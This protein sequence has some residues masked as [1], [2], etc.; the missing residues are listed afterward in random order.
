MLTKYIG[1]TGPKKSGKTTTIETILPLLSKK[2]L[3]VGTVKVAFKDVSID[4]NQEYYDVIR[5]RKSSPK[6]TLFKSSIETVVFRNEEHTLRQALKIIS[7]DLDIVLIEGF[8]EDLVGIPQITL[9]NENGQEK[10]FSSDYTVAIS[11]IPEFSIKSSHKLFVP[12]EKLAGIIIEK[13]LPLFPELDCVHCGYNTCKELM[14]AVIQGKK[15]IEDCEI[16]GLEDSPVVLKVNDKAV[17]SKDFIQ[18]LIKNVVAGIVTSLKIEE[19]EI[20]TVDL[21]ISYKPKKVID[22]E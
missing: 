19:K 10:E 5:H 15:K 16:L 22:D 21:K 20:S 18:D 6:I 2:G 11:S 9:L 7:E 3:R 12:F 13:S 1:I 4:V 17:P 14:I 8:K